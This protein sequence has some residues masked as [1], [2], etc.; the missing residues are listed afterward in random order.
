MRNKQICLNLSSRANTTAQ[1]SHQLL[2]RTYRFYLV[3]VVVRFFLP[4][5][6]Q[7][8]W[9]VL[10]IIIKS[11]YILCDIIAAQKC[12]TIGILSLKLNFE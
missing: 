6:S 3:S 7:S 8:G 9:N 12:E 2:T 10:N 5:K 4:S 1:S 11:I